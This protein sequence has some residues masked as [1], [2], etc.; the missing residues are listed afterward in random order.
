MIFLSVVSLNYFDV[1]ISFYTVIETKGSAKYRP[2]KT[3][4]VGY[5]TVMFCCKK[6]NKKNDIK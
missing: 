6:K 5:Q 4:D 3:L 1:N 2:P